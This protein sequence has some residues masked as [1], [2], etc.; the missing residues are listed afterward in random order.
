MLTRPPGTDWIAQHRHVWDRKPALRRVYTAWFRRLRAAC[1]ADGPIVELGCGPGFFKR[2]YPEVC[3][4]DAPGNPDADRVVDA[5]TLPF[6]DGSLGSLVMLDVFHHLDDPARFLAEAARTLR[7]GGRLVML[8]PWPGLA[9]TALYTWI[10]HEECDPRVDP[11][12][13]WSAPGKQSMQGNAALPSLY[14]GPGG[15]LGRLGLPLRLVCRERFAALPW[16][17][18][19]GFQP[20]TLLPSALVPAAEWLDGVL[21]KAPALTATRCFLVLERTA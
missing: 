6:A 5:A 1:A 20:M 21:S 3:A 4:T 7:V 10:H 9:G 18:S 13:P 2:A 11:A 19:G 12:A 17:L 15:H 8:E 16:I 14:F